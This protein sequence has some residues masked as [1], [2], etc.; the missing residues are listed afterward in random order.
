MK[1]IKIKL[2]GISLLLLVTIFPSCTDDLNQVPDNGDSKS[3]DELFKD[4]AS[5]KQFLAKIY[6]GLAVTG[7][8]GP[9]GSPD[10]SGVD[11]G[12]SDYLRGY[13]Y[14]QELTTDL[15]VIAW[16][17]A[18]IQDFHNQTWTSL[19]TFLNATYARFS[20]Q[21][22]NCNEFL[23]QTTDE[24]LTARGVDA[25]LKTEIGYFRAEARF[26]RALTYWH[27]LDAYGGGSLVTEESPIDFYYPDYATRAQLYDFVESELK[28]IIPL[29]KPRGNEKYR[30]DQGAAKML[31]ANLYMNAKVYVND[32]DGFN[33]AVPL[34]N[35]IIASGYIIHNPAGRNGYQELFL[36]DNDKNGAENEFIFTVASDGLNTQTFGGTTFLTHAA[37]GGSMKKDDFGINGGWG[38]IRT[39]S[40]FV[41]MFPGTTEAAN[42]SDTRGNFYK[43]GQSLEIKDIS[44]FTDGYAVQKFRNLTTAGVPGSDKKGDFVDS[45]FPL[46]RLADT[47]LLYAECAIRGASGAN[48]STAV[49]YVNA[50]RSRAKADVITQSQL[51]LPFILDERAREL[52]WE[53]H[54]RTDLVRFGKFT[55]GSYIW[56]WKGGVESGA[57]TQSYR[58]IFPIPA[59]ALSANTKLIQNPGY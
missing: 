23:R 53:L 37:V 31:L 46:F 24:K 57:P 2:L 48:L 13:Y 4:P 28:T 54:R 14:L 55:G 21:I 29:L 45:D 41:K 34:L 40:A 20:F 16:G 22:V 52:H 39:T 25:T 44:V 33:K 36:A 18:T 27:L 1:N 11:E 56:P 43:D 7:Q 5:Y 6:A 47:Y 51:T 42:T 59:N 49:T 17:D 9:A 8:Q 35:E 50:L 30:A 26:M 58:D 3:S 38:G 10:V 32:N 12:A 19:D 15:A